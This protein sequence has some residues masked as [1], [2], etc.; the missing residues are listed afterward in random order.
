MRVN[1]PFGTGA[2]GGGGG[3]GRRGVVPGVYLV[4]YAGLC[5]EEL[6]VEG[7]VLLRTQPSMSEFSC[8]PMAIQLQAAF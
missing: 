6:A 7:A 3:G 2:G 8:N 5:F 1:K 4:S